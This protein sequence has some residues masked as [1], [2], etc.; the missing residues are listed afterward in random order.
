THLKPYMFRLFTDA[1]NVRELLIH[2][3]RSQNF[4]SRNYPVYEVLFCEAFEI[5]DSQHLCLTKQLNPV[6]SVPTCRDRSG[7][8]SRLFSH[9]G[10]IQNRD[11][12]FFGGP[13]HAISALTRRSVFLP[14]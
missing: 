14:L 5:R 1:E 10:L 7:M 2:R 13:S 12:V 6:R 3:Y 8:G 9:T 4:E 11:P